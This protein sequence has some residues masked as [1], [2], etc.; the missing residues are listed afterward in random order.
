MALAFPLFVLLTGIGWTQVTFGA[1][2]NSAVGTGPSNIAVGDFN[3]D[4]KLD[5]A[6]ANFASNNISI[7][8]GNGNGTFQ[9]PFNSAVG[10]GPTDITVGDFN[11]DG[12]IDLAV[13]NFASNNISIL[14]ANGD[15]TFQAPVNYGAGTGPQGVSVGDFDGDG[16]L[17][18]AV[19]N[20]TS[21]NISVLLG[22]GNGA[23]VAATNFPVGT[24]PSLGLVVADFNG[25]G[26]LDLAVENSGSNNVS[27][28]LGAGAGSFGAAANFSVG[29]GP[30]G[31]VSGDF[32][33]DGQ[34]DLVSANSGNDNVSIL[35]NTTPPGVPGSFAG[36]VLG[37]SSVTYTWANVSAE[38]G[39]R[40]VSQTDVNVSGNL[41]ANTLTFTET[42]LSTNTSYNRRVVAFNSN[43]NSASTAINFY[44]LAAPPTSFALVNVNVSSIAVSWAANMN[45]GITSYR[46]DRWTA[47]SSTTSVTVSVT[48]AAL[49][50]LSSGTT[51]YLRVAA[52]NGDGVETLMSSAL[53]S[54]STTLV[55]ASA[56][57]AIGSGG[58]AI[59]F[60]SPSGPVTVTIPPGAFAL[61]VNVTLTSPTS[62]PG[63]GGPAA[64]MT[65]TG[66]GVQIT[67]DQ[68][69]Q[70]AVGARLSVSYRPSDVVGLDQSTL[71]LAR[72]DTTQN[73]WVPLVSSVDALNGIVVAQTTHFSTFQIMAAAPSSTVSTAK[74]FPNPLR[75]SLGQTSMTFSALPASA[76][77]RIYNLKGVLIKDI[78]ADASGMASWDATN[79]SGAAV[80][81]GVYFV[82]AQ[83][84]GQSRTLE[85]AVQR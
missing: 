25:D 67:L 50:G 44:T 55:A 11:A 32:N 46:V 65:G 71:I 59:P 66:V 61:P 4:G 75:P 40:I 64:N 14:L 76:R 1:A 51:Y 28:L 37:A 77:I 58:G 26:K 72:F 13:A 82:Y 29:N 23:F 30:N 70:P 57:G 84:A 10:T 21:N 5:L 63:G 34:P 15:G 56:S 74:A 33:L 22:V 36:S 62:F 54:T 48:S 78:T 17:D 9:A 69:V 68:A 53:L 2:A 52:L 38:T 60:A 45:P 20:Y 19:A 18:L 41:A 6:V 43:A 31:V 80:G 12:K 8:L 73:V 85:I 49:S 7:L 81:S 39:F 3:G 42:A 79:Q 47:G 27:V 83:G 16:K 24:N 35:L